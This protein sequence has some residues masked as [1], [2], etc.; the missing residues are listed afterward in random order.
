MAKNSP[1]SKVSKHLCHHWHE[2]R[3]TCEAYDA[4]LIR[5]G[6]NCELCGTPRDLLHVDHDHGIGYPAVRGL[7]CPKCNA[8]LRRV[9]SGER[10]AD[11][12]TQR[13]LDNAY[14]KTI[15]AA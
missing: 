11:E 1:H 13:F 8:H 2:Y 10:V 14:W 4:L 6:G 3:M 7:V 15:Y 5:A 9:D 12:R